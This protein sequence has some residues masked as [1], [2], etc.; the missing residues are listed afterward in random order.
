MTWENTLNHLRTRGT[1]EYGAFQ[2]EIKPDSPLWRRPTRGK[3]FDCVEDALF[4]GQGAQK[5]LSGTAP[6]P[7]TRYSEGAE[8]FMPYVATW[9]RGDSLALLVRQATPENEVTLVPVAAVDS[10]PFEDHAALTNHLATV[11]G[12]GARAHGVRFL[13][14]SSRSIVQR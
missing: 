14:P 9:L 8:L 4:N 6:Y 13:E 12:N 3:R 11:F 7:R 2:R 1:I 10:I 5:A